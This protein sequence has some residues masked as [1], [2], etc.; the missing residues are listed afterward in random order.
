MQSLRDV[1]GRLSKFEP[2]YVPLFRELGTEL[3][4]LDQEFRFPTLR[5]KICAHRDG[6]LDLLEVNEFWKKLT[7]YNLQRH[8]DV[9]TAHF[10]AMDSLFR[11]EMV[12]YFREPEPMPGISAPSIPPETSESWEPFDPPRFR[13]DSK[14]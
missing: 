9:F 14:F 8:L 3:G 1:L 12:Q 2:N 7:R 13:T 11:L 10:Q 4:R 6:N 5:R